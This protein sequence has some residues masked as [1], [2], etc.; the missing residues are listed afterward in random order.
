M[1]TSRKFADSALDD[2]QHSTLSGKSKLN[3]TDFLLVVIV[4]ILLAMYLH[5]IGK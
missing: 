3:N 4:K 1:K 5:S 2:F